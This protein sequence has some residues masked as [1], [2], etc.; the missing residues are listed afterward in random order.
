MGGPKRVASSEPE[1]E[2]WKTCVLLENV[3]TRRVTKFNKKHRTPPPPFYTVRG[4]DASNHF[5]NLL[6][7]N[8][9]NTERSCGNLKKSQ[10]E[11][12]WGKSH[13]YLTGNLTRGEKKEGKSKLESETRD[14][15]NIFDTAEL[16]FWSPKTLI[17]FCESGNWES[18]T[19]QRLLLGS[20]SLS[21]SI[22]LVEDRRQ[23]FSCQWLHRKS[24]AGWR[25]SEKKYVEE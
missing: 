10:S 24:V 23:E 11:P 7:K 25:L 5:P 19:E 15:I 22:P 6:E 1:I 4:G 17:R 18:E 14:Y 21:P 16:K 2:C 8:V 20:Q 12:L 3:V 13:R 9:G